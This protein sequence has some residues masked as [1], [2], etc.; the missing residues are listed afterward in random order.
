[1]YVMLS[2]RKFLE[3]GRHLVIQDLL[4]AKPSGAVAVG[5][6]LEESTSESSESCGAIVL[7]G[8]HP[9]SASERHV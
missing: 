4:P 9:R 5:S 6:V 7:P 8:V 2:T 3:S 1:M